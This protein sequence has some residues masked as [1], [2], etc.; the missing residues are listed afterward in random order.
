MTA[1]CCIGGLRVVHFNIDPKRSAKQQALDVR[2]IAQQYS[3]IDACMLASRHICCCGLDFNID[4][5]RST[6]Q[7]RWM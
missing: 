2:E 3:W 4:P 1:S 7:Q 5:T 6:K